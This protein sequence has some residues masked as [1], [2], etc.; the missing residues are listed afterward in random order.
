MKVTDAPEHTVILA[1]AMLTAGT[2]FELTVIVTAF[3]VAVDGDA[4]DE[5]DVSI[6]VT[7]WPLVKV[8]VV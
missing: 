4:H 7:I 5:L 6:Q 2:T 8:V 1:V 3:E